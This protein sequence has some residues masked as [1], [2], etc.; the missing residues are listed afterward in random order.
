[1]FNMKQNKTISYQSLLEF[2]ETKPRQEELFGNI[3]YLCGPPFI[4]SSEDKLDREYQIIEVLFYSVENNFNY[5]V[6]W[7]LENYFPLKV[8]ISNN[9]LLR[10][11][12]DNGNSTAMRLLANHPNFKITVHSLRL[13]SLIDDYDSIKKCMNSPNLPPNIALY[14]DEI[15]SCVDS[16]NT[17]NIGLIF[18]KIKY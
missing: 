4:G 17:N 14:K 7:I 13:L 9:K 12:F 18:N 10:I 8:S 15:I 6:K 3:I 1:M 16:D 5:I 2:L 11:A